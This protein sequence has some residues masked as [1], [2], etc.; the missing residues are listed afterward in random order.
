MPEKDFN[1][2]V[3]LNT[4]FRYVFI[5]LRKQEVTEKVFLIFF[6]LWIVG[7]GSTQIISGSVHL[8]KD[9]DQEHLKCR[10]FSVG[11]LEVTPLAIKYCYF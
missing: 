7:S 2:L 6:C 3:L 5:S 10:M 9:P 1:F 8:I 4:Y 11:E